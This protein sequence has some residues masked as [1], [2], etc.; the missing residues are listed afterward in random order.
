MKTS[1]YKESMTKT[2]KKIAIIGSGITACACAM[3][4]S[5]KKYKVEIYEKSSKI[6][7]IL[8]DIQYEKNIFLSGP[9]YIEKSEWFEKFL[10]SKNLKKLFKKIDIKYGSYTDLFENRVSIN[11]NYAHPIT[12]KPFENLKTILKKSVLDRINSYQP[13]ISEPLNNWAKNFRQDL[14]KIHYDCIKQMQISR[15]FFSNS[16]KETKEKKLKNAI[17]DDLL[18]IPSKNNLRKYYVPK[19]GYNIVFKT[20]FNILKKH[21]VNFNLNSKIKINKRDKLVFLNDNNEIK[22]DYILW[23]CNPVPLI[24]EINNQILENPVV[25]IFTFCFEIKLKSKLKNDIYFQ[26]FSKKTSINRIY[27]YKINNRINLNVECFGN[28]YLTEKIIKK[29]SLKILKKFGYSIKNIKFF[30][31]KKDLRHILFTIKDLES[32]EKFYTNKDFQNIIPGYWEEY[33]REKKISK[34]LKKISQNDN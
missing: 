28:K 13:N 34:I 26:V 14:E 6:G 21:G 19:N 30:V 4:L 2:K 31:M 15:V 16:I 8:R 5:K 3:M 12:K 33:S 11:K 22:A 24:K 1:I 20:I 7:G 29:D 32:F 10:R 18:G 17:A 23:A 9:Q 27:L 25:K